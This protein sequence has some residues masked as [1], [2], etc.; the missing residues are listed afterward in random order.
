MFV[1][2]YHRHHGHVFTVWCALCFILCAI[3]VWMQFQSLF[4]Y[5][6]LNELKFS[7]TS[8]LQE[9]SV[10]LDIPEDLLDIKVQIFFPLL[11]NISLNCLLLKCL[12]WESFCATLSPVFSSSKWL[13][14]GMG[15]DLS[16]ALLRPVPTSI[17]E[18]EKKKGI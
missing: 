7:R 16:S 5:S 3:S 8:Y 2:N 1:P 6:S 4:Y 17:N 10:G 9:V 13:W 11:T 12:F 15:A 14:I 18:K